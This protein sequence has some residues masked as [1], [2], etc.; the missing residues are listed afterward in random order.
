MGFH[1]TRQNFYK[2]S[3]AVTVALCVPL[4]V[5]EPIR[6]AG[7]ACWWDGKAACRVS[8]IPGNASL[9]RTPSPGTCR[10]A[11]DSGQSTPGDVLVLAGV[12]YEVPTNKVAGTGMALGLRG[13]FQEIDVRSRVAEAL[14][15]PW[16]SL[17]RKAAWFYWIDAEGEGGLDRVHIAGTELCVA[18][19]ASVGIARLQLATCGP[20][21]DSRKLYDQSFAPSDQAYTI[22]IADGQRS[23]I[24]VILSGRVSTAHLDASW[25]NVDGQAW[26]EQP[27]VPRDQPTIRLSE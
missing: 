5:Q 22:P 9:C 15:I 19:G 3:V 21:I 16:A 11:W 4:A 13:S 14:K 24:T 17:D 25:A 7:M 1:M 2:C 23:F 8:E 26:F 10:L 18:T 12:V 20:G 27:A 6:A